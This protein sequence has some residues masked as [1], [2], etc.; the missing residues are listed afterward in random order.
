MPPTTSPA[1]HG[2]A[3]LGPR[4]FGAGALLAGLGVFYVAY[5]DLAEGKDAEFTPVN[6]AFAPL[7]ITGMWVI[8]AA[9]FLV[10]QLVN[11]LRDY[12]PPQTGEAEEA[13]EEPEDDTADEQ[14]AA[15]PGEPDPDTDIDQADADPT[16]VR[17]KAP[18]LVVAS[19]V[20][21]VFALEDIGFIFTTALF[22]IAVSAI[23]GSRKIIRD[24]IVAALL[25][26]GIY[27]L[28]TAVL[29]LPLPSGELLPWTF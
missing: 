16:D 12:P 22:F 5:L 21:Y 18:A 27:Y 14:D 28:F 23:F 2:R 13:E 20:V 3:P 15:S 17:W 4:I 10:R 19:L 29:Y 9:V 26:V 25:A 1:R 7:L 8:L 24:V 6:A 11:P